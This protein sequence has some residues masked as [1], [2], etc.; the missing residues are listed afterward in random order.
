MRSRAGTKLGESGPQGV[1]DLATIQP[2]R[3]GCLPF[4][5]ALGDASKHADLALAQQWPLTR[6][7]VQ[8]HA[9]GPWLVARACLAWMVH[10]C[11]G[12]R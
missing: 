2:E 12:G 7:H 1:G 9:A 8:R 6:L 10:L 5:H 11:V 4:R 3:R